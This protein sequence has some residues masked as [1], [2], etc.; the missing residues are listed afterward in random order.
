MQDRRPLIER[1][2]G[3]VKLFVGRL[4]REV[5]Q[6]QLRECFEEFGE[7][8]EVFVIGTKAM[9]GVGCAFIRMTNLE[10]AETA[11]QE[12]HEQRV[13][14]PEQ[15][16]LGPM[17]VAFAKGEAIRL[18]LGEKEEILPSFKEARMKVVEHQEKRIFFE[19]MQKQQEAHQQVVIQQQQIQHQAVSAGLLATADLVELIK[20]GQRFGGPHFKQKWWSY[21]D[22][23]WAGVHDY[24]PKHHAH[25]TLSQF[26]SMAAYEHGVEPWFRS[27]FKDLPPPPAGALNGQLPQPLG[28]PPFGCPPFGPPGPPGMSPPFM[29]PLMPPPSGPCGPNGPC[30]PGMIGMPSMHGCPG[31]PHSVRPPQDA[32]NSTQPCD[33]SHMHASGTVKEVSANGRTMAS[34]TDSRKVQSYADVDALSMSSASD[35]A[36]IEDINEDDI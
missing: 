19:Q 27:R 29:P 34:K 11:I 18:G 10:Q 24:D 25:E 4:P 26:V 32:S 20:D 14:I 2:K 31:A 22:Q 33:A 36:N 13:L 12:L 15:R 30:G 16:D 6:K 8:L 7:V 1:E 28:M 9:S 5:T 3:G 17:Q 23:G 35:A 21:C